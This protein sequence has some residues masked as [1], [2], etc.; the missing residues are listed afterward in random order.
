MES[1]YDDIF[2]ALMLAA[3]VGSTAVKASSGFL[4][5]KYASPLHVCEEDLVIFHTV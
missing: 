5:P 3:N 2:D 4:K 1:P